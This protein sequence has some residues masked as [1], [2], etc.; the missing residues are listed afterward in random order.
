MSNALNLL[1]VVPMGAEKQIVVISGPDDGRR[2]WATHEALFPDVAAIM[3]EGRV[4][5]R[6]PFRGCFTWSWRAAGVRQWR[7]GVA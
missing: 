1:P 2:N 7:D 6:E 3:A 4:S 5:V